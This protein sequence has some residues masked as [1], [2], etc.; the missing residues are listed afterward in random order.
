MK[1]SKFYPKKFTLDYGISE[2]AIFSKDFTLNAYRKE[3][4]P[5]NENDPRYINPEEYCEDEVVDGFYIP[6]LIVSKETKR[7]VKKNGYLKYVKSTYNELYIDFRIGYENY[8]AGFSSKSR[9]TLRRKVKK[10]KAFSN[11]ELDW[12]VYKTVDEIMEFYHLAREVSKETYQEKIDMGLPSTEEFVEEL[13]NQALNDGVRGYLLFFEGKPI[14]YLYCPLHDKSYSYYRLGY[15]PEMGKYSVGTV[16]FV[17]AIEY[18][19]NE[20]NADFMH[21]F[22]RETATKVL[23]STGEIK[24]GN[25]V[26]LKDTIKNKFWIYLHYGLNYTVRKIS[27]FIEL[28][29]LKEVLKKIF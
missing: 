19:F 27:G 12:K 13:K 25:F 11:D 5:F 24:C 2:K 18:M 17:L 23:F 4:S 10:F 7:L 8:M 29:G 1:D 22:E 14:S 6:S 28:I 3:Y 21:F 26:I 9:S 15:L 16:L 20:K